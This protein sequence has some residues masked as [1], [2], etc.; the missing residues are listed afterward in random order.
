MQALAHRAGTQSL[1]KI[2]QA[3]LCE[4]LAQPLSRV[5]C[6]LCIWVLSVPMMLPLG[7]CISAAHL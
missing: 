7:N 1:R 4:P 3:H 6:M 5:S 2:P